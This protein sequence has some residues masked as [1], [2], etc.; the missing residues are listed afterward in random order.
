MIGIVDYGR[1]NV[2]S[3][4]NACAFLGVQ[5]ELV[6][7]PAAA[8]QCDGLVVPGQGHFGDC[9]RSLRQ[10][11]FDQYITEWI[12]ADRP[13]FGICVGL[14]LLFEGSEESPT[15]TGLGVLPGVLRKFESDVDHKVPQMGWNRVR[16]HPAGSGLFDGVDDQSFFYFVH[17]YYVALEG[18]TVP[19]WVGSTTDYG[20]NYVSSVCQGAL[21]A[22]QFHPE[23]SQRHGLHLLRNFLQ[24]TTPSTVSV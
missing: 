7:S 22:T 24:Q 9:V 23:K 20:V 18:D 15:D 17:S 11:G 16:K 6:A 13:L 1:G 2:G 14:Q 10:A 8:D 12:A 19:E 21:W 5:A 4:L 3:V